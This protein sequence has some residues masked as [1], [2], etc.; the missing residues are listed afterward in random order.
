MDAYPNY[1]PRW[2]RY[3]FASGNGKKAGLS[4]SVL[5]ADGTVKQTNC[6]DV[7]KPLA[8]LLIQIFAG[9]IILRHLVR[10]NF[11]LGGVPRALYAAHYVGLE[12]ISF[13]D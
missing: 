4:A 8:L 6:S 7:E 12:R 5:R 11:A 1:R 3:L 10:A 13:L 9:D 2:T